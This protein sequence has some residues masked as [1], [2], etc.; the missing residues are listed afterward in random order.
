MIGAL[1]D[2]VCAELVRG[3]SPA[4]SVIVTGGAAIYLPAAW[5]TRVQHEP[6]LTLIGLAE[7][8]RRHFAH[9]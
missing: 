5:Q 8:H 3:G 1:L 2:G 7:A 6:H 4:P 9:G